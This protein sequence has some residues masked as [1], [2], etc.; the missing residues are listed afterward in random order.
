MPTTKAW[1]YVLVIVIID[2]LTKLYFLNTLSYGERIP[3]LPFFDFVLLFNT[4]AAFS[5]LANHDGWQRWFFVGIG[6]VAIIVISLFLRRHQHEPRFMWG[7]TL[8]LGGAIGNVIDRLLW[9]HVVDFLLFFYDNWYYPAFNIA[10]SCITVG[11][12]LIIFDE[13][14]KWR[15]NRPIKS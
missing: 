6:F 5:F 15:T 8:I 2:Q 7:L 13:I 9:G 12:I 3:V 10:D 4:G 11:A 1:G 14:F